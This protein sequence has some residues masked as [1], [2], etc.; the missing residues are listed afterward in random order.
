VERAVSFRSERDQDPRDPLRIATAPVQVEAAPLTWLALLLSAGSLY[1]S[2]FRL[3]YIPIVAAGDQWINIHGAVRMLNGETIYKDFFQYTWPGT[4]ALYATLMRIF[5]TGL[6]LIPAL[7]V[8]VGLAFVWLGIYISKQVQLG[9]AAVLPSLMY[10][11]FGRAGIDATHHKF[12]VLFVLAA[13]A[14]M[15]PRRNSMRLASAGALIGVAAF[16]TQSRSICLLGLALFLLWEARQRS[17]GW[18]HLLAQECILF[19]SFAASAIA[20]LWCFVKPIGIA[21]FIRLTV[22]FPLYYYRAQTEAN[23]WAGYMRPPA[24]A[25]GSPL[26]LPCIVMWALVPPIYLL[27]FVVYWNRNRTDSSTPW[28]GLMLVNLVGLSLFLSIGYAPIWPRLFEISLPALILAISLICRTRY[29]RLGRVCIWGGVVAGIA[30]LTIRQQTRRC[31]PLRT[32]NGT[33]AVTDPRGRRDNFSGTAKW[34]SAHTRPGDAVFV[35]SE[36][37]L[38]TVLGLTNPTELAF[39]TSCAYTRP[40]QVSAAI[41][42]MEKHT[43]RYVVWD[44]YLDTYGKDGPGDNLIPLRGFLSQRFAPVA[45]FP[46]GERILAPRANILAAP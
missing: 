18:Q 42:T 15:I 29:A 39:V 43:P 7:S 19:L 27:F 8:F 35:A 41:A 1:L 6:W 23:T 34:L 24:I 21:A 40:E 5:G 28:D 45:V 31:L 37:V 38:Y 12:S 2:L 4:E 20:L 10:L 25:M 13:T 17:P 33:V 36:P 16:F 11:T 22:W 14:I 9:S 44:G 30:A 46:D 32:A 3:P 26:L